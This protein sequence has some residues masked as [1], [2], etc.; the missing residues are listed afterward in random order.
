MEREYRKNFEAGKARVREEH[1]FSYITAFDHT[2][3][4]QIHRTMLPPADSLFVR[5]IETM[6][7]RGYY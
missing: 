6:V 4:L 1:I 2:H 3:P 7:I 5:I